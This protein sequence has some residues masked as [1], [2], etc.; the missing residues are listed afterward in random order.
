MS[1]KYFIANNPSSSCTS[2][3][4]Q[5][6]ATIA[7]GNSVTAL[8]VSAGNVTLA[9][10]DVVLTAGV[11]DF[12]SSTARTYMMKLPLTTGVTSATLTSTGVAIAGYAK[13]QMPS[14][15]GATVARYIYLYA[16][17]PT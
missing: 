2:A 6:L 17:A 14:A 3:Q 8:A 5:K 4:A 16:S 1:G 11:L 10:G 13:V 15:T 9:A 12:T 7:T